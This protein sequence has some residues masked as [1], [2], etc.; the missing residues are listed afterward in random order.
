MQFNVQKTQSQGI[1]FTLL[2]SPQYARSVDNGSFDSTL[3]S[4]D[5][6]LLTLPLYFT[7]YS[8]FTSCVFLQ[9]YKPSLVIYNI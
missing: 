2:C 6:I 9:V 8:I 7:F 1:S 4:L 5:L 3:S